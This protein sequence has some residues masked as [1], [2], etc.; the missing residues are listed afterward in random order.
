MYSDH[1]DAT[2]RH[3]YCCACAV[4]TFL[5][6]F[7]R[8]NQKVTTEHAQ[9]IITTPR[10]VRTIAEI[11]TE[12]YSVPLINSKKISTK[13]RQRRNSQSSNYN[14]THI[15]LGVFHTVT[16]TWTTRTK[17]ENVLLGLFSRGKHNESPTLASQSTT[18][19]YMDC[20][21]LQPPLHYTRNR[22]CTNCTANRNE[23]L[24]QFPEWT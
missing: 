10:D 13:I 23:T 17:Q 14:N 3:A 20:L 24:M 1:V 4:Y 8:S 6:E 16:L 22:T 18:L 5:V 9:L 2:W 15:H 21:S 11:W 12:R 19:P 7:P